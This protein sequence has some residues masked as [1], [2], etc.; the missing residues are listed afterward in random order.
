MTYTHILKVVQ[1][2]VRSSGKTCLP[3]QAGVFLFTRRTG[4]LMHGASVRGSEVLPS[5]LSCLCQ[6]RRSFS[7]HHV[8]LRNKRGAEEKHR[9]VSAYQSG[10]PK[11]SSAQ[12][13][14]LVFKVFNQSTTFTFV[15]LKQCFYWKKKKKTF[16]SKHCF[17]ATKTAFKIP[18]QML[19]PI[20]LVFHRVL[21]WAISVYTSE[22]C[23]SYLFSL[24]VFN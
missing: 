3:V 24:F 22:D 13:G 9:S 20:S 11:V 15:T 1:Q 21:F 5:S 2:T 17:L 18:W 19:T 4:A 10:S 12:K 16:R 8:V 7:L 14:M 6:T 23:C